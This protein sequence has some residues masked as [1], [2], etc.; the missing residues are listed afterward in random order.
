[1]FLVLFCLAWLAY[2]SIQEHST[3][4]PNRFGKKSWARL[5]AK[6]QRQSSKSKTNCFRVRLTGESQT[7][8]ICEFIGSREYENAPVGKDILVV[9]VPGKTGTGSIATWH[10]LSR[11]RKNI[12]FLKISWIN[13]GGILTSLLLVFLGWRN[14]RFPR[15]APIKKQMAPLPGRP[16][17]PLLFLRRRWNLLRIKTRVLPDL[18]KQPTGKSSSAWSREWENQRQAKKLVVFTSDIIPLHR[19][20]QADLRRVGIR[21]SIYNVPGDGWKWDGFFVFISANIDPELAWLVIH[22]LRPYGLSQVVFHRPMAWILQEKTIWIG[23][24]GSTPGNSVNTREI[25]RLKDFGNFL[26]MMRDRTRDL[27]PTQKYSRRKFKGRHQYLTELIRSGGD[28]ASEIESARDD[29]TPRDFSFLMEAWQQAVGDRERFV[30]LQLLQ[31]HLLTPDRKFRLGPQQILREVLE[32]TRTIRDDSY[33]EARA[34]ALCGL[35]G[36]F[37]AFMKYREND[38]LAARRAAEFLR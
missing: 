3:D 19:Q 24:L 12:S 32:R 37:N 4:E 17:S 8:S 16:R 7:R 23:H 34:I 22:L 10:G 18:A 15:P 14:K 33:R 20:I 26:L 27:I 2:A 21:S 9:S 11:Y 30:V 13:F 38:A 31:D 5:L 35:E 29:I 25:Y 36:D 28:A 1:M 6:Y